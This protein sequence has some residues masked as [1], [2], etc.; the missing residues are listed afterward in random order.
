MIRMVSSRN[1]DIPLTKLSIA[2][3]GATLFAA[4]AVVV[5]SASY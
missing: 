1:R 4:T 2:E 5:G 3:Q